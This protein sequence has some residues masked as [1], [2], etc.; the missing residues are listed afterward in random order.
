VAIDVEVN[1]ILRVYLFLLVNPKEMLAL[2][3]CGAL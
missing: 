3:L 1:R 2:Q